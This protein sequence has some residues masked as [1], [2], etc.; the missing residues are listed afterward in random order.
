M[1]SSTILYCHCAFA[2]VVPEDV[3]RE[4][5]ER[6]ATSGQEF[7]SVADL[8]EMSATQDPSLKQLAQQSGLRIAACYPRAVKWLFSAAGAKLAEDAQIQNMRTQTADE[9][10]GELLKVSVRNEEQS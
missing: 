4:V 2:K 1:T 9:V 8:C 3:K 7:D 10:A 6:L 5:L